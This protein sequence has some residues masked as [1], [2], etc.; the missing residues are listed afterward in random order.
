MSIVA[1]NLTEA[2]TAFETAINH[3]DTLPPPPIGDPLDSSGLVEQKVELGVLD[4]LL[5][6]KAATYSA[7]SFQQLAISTGAMAMLNDDL[8]I[9]ILNKD[10]CNT[11]TGILAD[12]YDDIVNKVND[13]LAIT[14][15]SLQSEVDAIVSAVTNAIQ[16]SKDAINSIFEN[17][18][19]LEA[20]Q[21][22][23][24]Q[25]LGL[26]NSILSQGRDAWNSIKCCMAFAGL[27]DSEILSLSQEIED[28]FQ[29]ID[30]GLDLAQALAE[31]LTNIQTEL[32]LETATLDISASVQGNK[33]WSATLRDCGL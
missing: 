23:A 15:E 16:T 25:F 33:Y 17:V 20:L 28:T 24:F 4:N 3:I 11:F 29:K 13:I 32:G 18:S 19:A 2:N 12:T 6:T 31:G 7:G 21:L 22:H 10:I 1:S 9:D 30:D 8:N 14:S 5:N 26:F 27:I